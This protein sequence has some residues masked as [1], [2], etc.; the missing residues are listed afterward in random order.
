M[1]LPTGVN[2]PTTLDDLT[3]SS[4]HDLTS[5][6]TLFGDPA[7]QVELTLSGTINSSVDT[8]VVSEAITNIKVP[9]FFAFAT[10]EIVY[11]EAMNSGTKTF[12]TVTRG[13]DTTPQGHNSGEKL[14]LIVVAQQIIQLKT[15]IVAIETELGLAPKGTYATVKARLDSKGAASGYASLNGSTLVVENPANATATP[16]ASKI[17]MADGSG[18][19]DGWVSAMSDTVPGKVEAATI[20]ETNTGSDAT[21]AVTPDGLAG[22]NFGIKYIACALNGAVALTTNDVAYFR[23]PA[24]LTGMNLV[25]VT[26]TNGTGA[27]GASSS[28][29]PTFTVTNVTDGTAM[30]STSL[31]IDATEYT[32]ATAAT[33]AVIDTT[34]DDVVTD[35][36]IK[37]AVTTSGTGTTYAVV[38]LGFQLP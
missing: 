6:V 38:T 36:L 32:S 5:S 20:A 24:G 26:G 15:A 19:I 28:G 7:N 12:S 33:P 8:F 31:T 34:K 11:A 2:Y 27:A 30:L 4:T 37:I 17:V 13:V 22:S 16:T 35:D 23:I 21:R 1:T 18:K 14:R 3:L 25:S 29:N 10:G 9:V